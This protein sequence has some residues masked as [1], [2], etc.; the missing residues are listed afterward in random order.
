MGTWGWPRREADG[1]RSRQLASQSL[2]LAETGHLNQQ[3]LLN[4]L[5]YRKFSASKTLQKLF[6]TR[7]HML[8]ELRS[9]RLIRHPFRAR[10]ITEI[11]GWQV[12][13]FKEFRLP[14]PMNLL[15]KDRRQE[16][17]EALGE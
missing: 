12:D 5:I 13:M 7:Q 17:A 10:I 1:W 14:V 4:C 3:T 16:F 11:V 6:P 8:E 9:I 15:P 2:H